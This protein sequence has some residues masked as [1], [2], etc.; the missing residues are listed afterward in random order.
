M[1]YILGSFK[2]YEVAMK[3]LSDHF[4]KIA[5]HGYSICSVNDPK[6]LSLWLYKQL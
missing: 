1:K 3:A 4:Q 5:L 2:A 6:N